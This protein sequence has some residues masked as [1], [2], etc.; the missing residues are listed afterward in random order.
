VT[1]ATAA[2]RQAAAVSASRR[3]TFGEGRTAAFYRGGLDAGGAGGVGPLRRDR[4]GAA[5]RGRG[6]GAGG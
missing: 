3:M 6:G 2:S 1:M 5:E 4:G